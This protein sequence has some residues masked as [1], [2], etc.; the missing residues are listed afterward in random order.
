MQDEEGFESAGVVLGGR[1]LKK[2][3]S[4]LI[5]SK[6]IRGPISRSRSARCWS[7]PAA[8]CAAYSSATP[9]DR[10]ARRNH[11]LPGCLRL[12]LL[13]AAAAATHLGLLLGP[14]DPHTLLGIHLPGRHS[15]LAVGETV[16]LLTPPFHPH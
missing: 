15:H 2:S 7:P 10:S 9:P 14:A 5:S 12:R 8:A 11:L 13:S 3:F 1:T 6:L 4:I 16:I